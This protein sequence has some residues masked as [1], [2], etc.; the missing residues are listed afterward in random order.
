MTLDGL[1]GSLMA[2]KQRMNEMK[3]EEAL[4]SQKGFKKEMESAKDGA[5]S[6]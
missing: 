3:I 5:D 4:P 2:H 6:H 1:M